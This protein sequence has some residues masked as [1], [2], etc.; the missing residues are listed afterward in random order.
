MLM[1]AKA[2]NG[3]KAVKS[4]TGLDKHI[5]MYVCV[6]V[7]VCTGVEIIC[8]PG[9]PEELRLMIAKQSWIAVLHLLLLKKKIVQPWRSSCACCATKRI[10]LKLLGV[11][12]ET[13]EMRTVKGLTKKKTTK[14]GKKVSA[15]AMPFHLRLLMVKRI[16]KVL[17]IKKKSVSRKAQKHVPS[18]QCTK[19][20]R[21]NF[22][23]TTIQSNENCSH[24]MSVC[25]SV[26]NMSSCEWRV[27]VSCNISRPT[28]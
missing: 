26:H 14:I 18:Q 15:K 11:G 9:N 16:V 19:W 28:H 10:G 24:M 23:K 21:G 8:L 2:K 17:T 7:C 22:P 3:S 13:R 6:C 20:A 4:E 1:I 27:N 12:K 5:W 25:T